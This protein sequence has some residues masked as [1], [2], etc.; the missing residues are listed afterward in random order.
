MSAIARRRWTNRAGT[1]GVILGLVL[2]VA[3]TAAPILWLLLSSV[4]ENRALTATPP[5]LS[6]ASF[7]LANYREVLASS[8][9]LVQGLVNSLIVAAFST[10]A[11]LTLGAPAAYALARLSVPGGGPVLL[12]I[13]AT[14]ML[15]GIAI[16]IPL[17][18]VMSRLGL[19]D[20][21]A[22][23]IVV[24]LS[25]NMPIVIWVLR[26]FFL[27]IPAGLEKAAAVDGAGV[28]RT[29]RHIVLPISLPPLFATA[30]FAFIEAW[31]EFF[32]ALILTRRD[33]QTVPLAIS[34]FAGQYQTAFGP[35]MAAAAL[36]VA[37]VVALA[38]LFRRQIMLGFTEGVMKG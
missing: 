37:P 20:S 24:Y 25:F 16:A 31:N 10:A 7:T 35:M 14:Q 11:A 36:S 28:L 38:V 15:P 33:A 29:L 27:S 26:G 5:D 17:F 3:W 13:L 1:A 23:L 4:L 9:G 22:S 18:I 32:F 34:Q 30:I 6:P 21:R 19:I 8:A 2:F 12:T